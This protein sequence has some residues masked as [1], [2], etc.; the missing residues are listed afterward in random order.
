MLHFL[1]TILLIVTL[2]AGGLSSHDRLR[3]HGKQ[4]PPGFHP[5][6]H[7]CDGNWPPPPP[8]GGGGN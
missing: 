6:H 8:P 5:V 2:L 4:L 7:I 3:N 1:P